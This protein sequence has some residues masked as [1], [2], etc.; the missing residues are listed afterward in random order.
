MFRIYLRDQNQQVSD[1]TNTGNARA[2]IAAF[3]DLVDRTDLDGQRIMAV[4][5][6]NGSPIAHHKFN[7]R[8]DDKTFFWRCRIDQLPITDGA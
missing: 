6:K 1:K 5:T 7:A 2:A 3:E 4:I 8:K